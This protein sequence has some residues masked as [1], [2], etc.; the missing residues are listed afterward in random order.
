MD[1]IGGFRTTL[2]LPK[3]GTSPFRKAKDALNDADRAR[4]SRALWIFWRLIQRH[5]P[6][7]MKRPR[8]RLAKP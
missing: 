2:A 4:R 8:H 6:Q 3:A 7:E 1:P 5:F